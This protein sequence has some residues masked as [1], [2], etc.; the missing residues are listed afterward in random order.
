[1]Y[2]CK[3]K[4][5]SIVIAYQRISIASPCSA[6]VTFSVVPLWDELLKILLQFSIQKL[7]RRPHSCGSCAVLE[8]ACSLRS[9]AEP[10]VERHT[11]LRLHVSVFAPA[12]FSLTPLP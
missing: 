8:G 3:W 7:S 4:K 10:P 11:H 5:N 1:M 6:K 12:P 2:E 9:R